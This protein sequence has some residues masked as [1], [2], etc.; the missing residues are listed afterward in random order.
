[1]LLSPIEQVTVTADLVYDYSAWISASLTEGTAYLAITFWQKHHG[2]WKQVGDPVKTNSVANTLGEWSQVTGSAQAPAEAEYARAEATLSKYSNGQAWFDDLD[3]SQSICL[4]ITKSGTP[5]EVFPGDVLTYIITSANTGRGTATCEVVETYDHDVYL[6][7]S[8]TDP[9]PDP[10]IGDN[11]WPLGELGPDERSIIT[12]V[13]QVE[14]EVEDSLVE[15]RVVLRCDEVDVPIS[16]LLVTPLPTDTCAIDLVPPEWQDDKAVGPG[17]TVIHNMTLRN[18]GSCEGQG[19][20]ETSCPLGWTCDPDPST[21]TL[22]TASEKPA[23]LRLDI[24]ENT[25]LGTYEIGVTA[26]LECELPC[27][28]E[29]ADC[30]DTD[31]SVAS[32]VY[33]PLLINWHD[34]QWECADPNGTCAAA[35]GPI[36]CEREYFGYTDDDMDTWQIDFQS[37]DANLVVDFTVNITEAHSEGVQIWIAGHG[38]TTGCWDNTPEDG[39]K[40]DC[41]LDPGSYCFV[42][43]TASPLQ[44]YETP[45]IIWIPCSR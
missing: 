23:T 43:Y 22:P 39:Y 13:V 14:D 38:D 15:N 5:D 12:P 36:V 45:Y 1:M 33:M 2:T 21:F 32:L 18:V 44:S 41:P 37:Y 19:T 31:M 9:T 29:D 25:P 40:L 16:A 3:L 24:S 26:T 28:S 35:C 8:R 34:S 20:L 4:T 7:W 17:Q 27:N 10:E 30:E 42:V 11:I 6:L